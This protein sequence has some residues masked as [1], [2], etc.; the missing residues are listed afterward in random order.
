MCEYYTLPD[1]SNIVKKD[2]EFV[3][4]KLEV[5]VSHYAERIVQK[6]VFTGDEEGE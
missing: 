5:P 4:S 6:C 2:S 3:L 1:V